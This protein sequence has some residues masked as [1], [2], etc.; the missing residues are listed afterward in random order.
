MLNL[1]NRITN[2]N[3]KSNPKCRTRAE[4]IQKIIVAISISR[5]TILLINSHLIN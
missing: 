1:E 4:R 2:F 3:S 5:N